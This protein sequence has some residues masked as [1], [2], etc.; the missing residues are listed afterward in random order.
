MGKPR[1]QTYTMEMYLKRMRNQDIRSDQDVQRLSN[2][3]S[4]SMTNELIA[5]VLNGEYI[6]P[7]ILGQEPNSQ[8]WVIDGLQR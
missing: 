6:P 8:I 4:N 1:K 3:W 7:I 5:S 2:Q